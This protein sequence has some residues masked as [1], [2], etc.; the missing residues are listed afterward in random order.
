MYIILRFMKF[1]GRDGCTGYYLWMALQ[2]VLKSGK[3][4]TVKKRNRERNDG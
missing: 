4:V 2:D 1:M 3:D